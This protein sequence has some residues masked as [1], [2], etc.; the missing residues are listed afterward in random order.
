MCRAL[1]LVHVLWHFGLLVL[2]ILH[3]VVNMTQYGVDR[4]FLCYIEGKEGNEVL[5]LDLYCKH[6]KL[7]IETHEL[8]Y[9]AV[10]GVELWICL[11]VGVFEKQSWIWVEIPSWCQPSP[12]TYHGTRTARLP[13][14]HVPSYP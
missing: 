12:K 7:Q 5:I 3:H 1:T 8:D 6:V 11:L 14:L 9:S 4:V 10:E 2:P 13:A